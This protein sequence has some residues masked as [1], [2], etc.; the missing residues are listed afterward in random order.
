MENKRLFSTNLFIINK[1]SNESVDKD[2]KIA[3]IAS[4]EGI[5]EDGEQ[6]LRSTLDISYLAKR[7]TLNWNHRDDPASQL[8]SITKAEIIP[9]GG[10]A[11]Y[12]DML[13][14]SLPADSTI[15][16]EGQ[17]YKT[18]S[19][20]KSVHDILTDNNARLGLSIEGGILYNKDKGIKKVFARHCAV[21]PTPSQSDTLC[22][23]AKSLTEKQKLD[24]DEILTLIM[25]R[26]EWVNRNEALRILAALV[27]LPEYAP[28]VYY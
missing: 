12:E 22:Q 25:K 28:E 15:Y 8:G 26:Y 19:M 17:L 27:V 18:L 23:L 21:T 16:I 3:G 6:L 9:D 24:R 5:D 2:W 14:K 7:G 20:A 11:Y 13:G 1:N 10:V 4:S